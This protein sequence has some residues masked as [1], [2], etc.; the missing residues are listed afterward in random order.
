MDG[1]LRLGDTVRLRKVH[2][3]GGWDW[4]VVRLGADVGLRCHTC[5]RRIMLTRSELSRR[6]RGVLDK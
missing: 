6:L 2:P 4:E 5:G 1:A 3:C